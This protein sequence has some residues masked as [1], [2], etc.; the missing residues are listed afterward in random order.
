[1]AKKKKKIEAVT[2]KSPKKPLNVKLLVAVILSS[3]LS[4]IIYFGLAELS[5]ALSEKA[6][7]QIYIPVMEIYTILA[8]ILIGATVVVNAGMRRGE[9]PTELDLPDE[10]SSERKAKFLASVPKHKNSHR[11]RHQRAMCRKSLAGAGLFPFGHKCDIR[12]ARAQRPC[13]RA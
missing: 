2:E 6:G 1:M 5:V 10:W 4:T 7:E 12:H 8:A 11:L 3:V 9:M 13:Q